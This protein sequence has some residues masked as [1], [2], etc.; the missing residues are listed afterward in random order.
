[1]TTQAPSAIPEVTLVNGMTCPLLGFGTYELAPGEE[2]YRAVLHALEHGYRLI[3]TAAIYGNEADIGKA[4]RHSNIPREDILVTTK[5]WSSDHGYEKARKACD[6]SLRRLDTEWVDLYLIHWP[7]GG[8]IPQ[9]WRAL[10]DL[11]AAGSCRAIGVSNFSAVD[12]R[13][14][15]GSSTVRPVVNQIE[16]NTFCYPRGLI[17]YC[18][19]ERIEIEAYSPLA[20]GEKLDHPILT[21]VARHCARTPAQVMLRWAIQHRLIAIPKSSHAER[22]EANRDLFDFE[23]A[24]AD[25]AALDGITAGRTR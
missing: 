2:S 10:E 18:R 6:A 3:D 25:M 16:A 8:M 20:R 22:I 9:T 13:K 5:L 4:I 15:L 21:D 7:G 19:S 1:M 23:I 14:L 24:A 17:D 12:L 11:A